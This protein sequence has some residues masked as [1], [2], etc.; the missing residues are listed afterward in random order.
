MPS[1]YSRVAKRAPSMLR[2]TRRRG[3]VAVSNLRIAEEW[4]GVSDLVQ[5]RL[6]P[7]HY[8][9][10]SKEPQAKKTDAGPDRASGGALNTY[11]GAETKARWLA[12]CAQRRTNPGA[13]LRRA[14]LAELEREM[15]AEQGAPG[16]GGRHRQVV[17]RPDDG[18][19]V[20]LELR[21]TPSELAAVEA[22][23]EAE[24]C[25]K[26]FWIICALR[27]ALTH[28]PQYTMECAKAV[29]NSNSQLLAIGRNL[30]QIAKALNAG[31]VGTVTTQRIDELRSVIQAHTSLVSKLS[32]ASVQ[33]WLVQ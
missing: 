7:V 11:L 6:T 5:D 24:S 8:A 14:V 29:W 2:R 18:E 21:L 15:P 19:K 32:N 9:H 33:R 30:N 28:E 16:R 25:S 26:Q 17:D 22:S 23:A 3:L 31:G 4:R 13:A 27:G 1:R 10:M 20:R 12:L